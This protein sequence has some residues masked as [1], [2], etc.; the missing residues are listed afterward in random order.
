M[1]SSTVTQVSNQYNQ[2]SDSLSTLGTLLI[3]SLLVHLP[4]FATP[5]DS[6]ALAAFRAFAESR[7]M[8]DTDA[9][10]PFVYLSAE[11][12]FRPFVPARYV[13][14]KRE[15]ERTIWN[16]VAASKGVG[17]VAQEGGVQGVKHARAIR[18]LFIRPSEFTNNLTCFHF[19]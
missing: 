6:A 1:T 5:P 2:R 18:P 15:A 17:Q 14:T 3:L 16:E 9:S 13:E 19:C 12:V 7:S 8:C 11:D 4:R 10:S